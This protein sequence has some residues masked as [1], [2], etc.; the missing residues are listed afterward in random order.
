MMS[1][2]EIQTALVALGYDRVAVD[3]VLGDITMSAIADFQATVGLLDDGIAGPKTQA[4]LAIAVTQKAK[5]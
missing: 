2:T 5:L 3:G 1:V 4:A